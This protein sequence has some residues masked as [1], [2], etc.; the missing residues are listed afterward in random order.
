MIG[1][2]RFRRGGFDDPAHRPAEVRP[3]RAWHHGE[4]DCEIHYTQFIRHQC[5]GTGLTRSTVT[6][7]LLVDFIIRDCGYD[8]VLVQSYVDCETQGREGHDSKHSQLALVKLPIL[9]C[10]KV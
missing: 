9:C 7:I 6:K 3:G 1:C 2:R 5:R 8:T 4:I 10:I